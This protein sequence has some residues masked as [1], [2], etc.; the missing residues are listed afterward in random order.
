MKKPGIFDP[1]RQAAPVPEKQQPALTPTEHETVVRFDG[2]RGGF[3]VI[4][5]ATPPDEAA[6]KA[7]TRAI[8][9]LKQQ[10]VGLSAYGILQDANGHPRTY[11][12]SDGKDTVV[13]SIEHDDNRTARHAIDVL[14]RLFRDA[15]ATPALASFLAKSG[16]TPYLK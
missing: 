10:G 3:S 16:I 1:W 14:C 8:L 2:L 4:V 12:L 6:K 7:L 11:S 13:V 9:G 5:R 15:Q